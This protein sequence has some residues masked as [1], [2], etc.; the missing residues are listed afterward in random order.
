MIELEQVG[1]RY[2]SEISGGQAQRVAVARAVAH[3]PSVL[4]MDEP[5]GALD[6][7]LRETMQTELRRIQQ[8]LGITAVYVTHDQSEAMNM[9]DRV[10]V[11]NLGVIEQIGA[12][13]EIY[14]KPA[15]VFVANFIG[16]VNIINGSVMSHKGN[17]T[18]LDNNGLSLNGQYDGKLSKGTAVHMAVRPEDIVITSKA[19]TGTYNSLK[20][21]VSNALFSGNVMKVSV[22][23]ENGEVIK[24]ECQPKTNVHQVGDT[25]HV[26]WQPEDCNILLT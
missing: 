13:K 17:V 10:V 16:Q 15:S 22:D 4:L 11:M 14:N 25:V 3:P 23:L 2:P 21:V 6:L 5:L 19:K 7:K 1:H 20:G 26:N 12:P 18:T 8:E 24:V 9:S